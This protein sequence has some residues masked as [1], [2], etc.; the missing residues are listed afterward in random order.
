ML[1]FDHTL[2]ASLWLDNSGREGWLGFSERREIFNPANNELSTLA[3][4][5]LRRRAGIPTSQG[6]LISTALPTVGRQRVVGK[7]AASVTV[8]G[9]RNNARTKK[10]GELKVA[11]RAIGAA[12][13]GL[14]ANPMESAGCMRFRYARARPSK[15]RFHVPA[16]VRDEAFDGLEIRQEQCSQIVCDCPRSHCSTESPDTWIMDGMVARC[17]GA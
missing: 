5:E 7:P 1:S 10:K 15:D 2:Q 4:A 12:L 13:Q 6:T 17:N 8:Q 16:G 3:Q 11:A 9:L 14:L